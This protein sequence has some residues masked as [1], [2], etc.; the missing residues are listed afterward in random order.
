[1]PEISC[2]NCNATNPPGSKFC[3]GCGKSLPAV[4]PAVSTF[5]TG[6]CSNCGRVNPVGSK[7]CEGCGT[8]LGVAPPELKPVGAACPDCGVISPEGSKFCERCGKRLTPATT[9]E[10]V[11]EPPA[12]VVTVPTPPAAD[13]DAPLSA[14]VSGDDLAATSPSV[15]EPPE[16]EIQPIIQAP[17]VEAQTLEAEPVSPKSEPPAAPPETFV[18]SPV[19]P[20]APAAQAQSTSENTP[21]APAS[22]S[23]APT[24]ITATEKTETPIV[25]DSL[26]PVAPLVSSSTGGAA[27]Q[28]ATT[29]PAFQPNS[30]AAQLCPKCG[31]PLLENAKFCEKCGTRTASAPSPAPA[32]TTPTW[33]PDPGP[34]TD[35]IF[36]TPQSTSKGPFM[37]IA[38]LLVVLA[39]AGLAAWKFFSGPDVTV[40]V[41]QPRVTASP[42]E[43]VSLLAS[44]SGSSDTD[45][46]WS[47]KEG[48]KGGRLSPE[49]VSM[50][51]G[52]VQSAASYLA[53]QQAGTYHVTA[54]S[55]ANS[56]R[57]AIIE[58]VVGGG[59]ASGQNSSGSA[60]GSLSEQI[61]GTWQWPKPADDVRMQIAADGSITIESASQ[62]TNPRRGTYRISGDKHIEVKMD[63]GETRKFDLLSIDGDS[64][65]V[66]SE[67][68]DGVSAM[69][70]TRT[71]TGH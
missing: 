3:Q 16:K 17:N 61:V 30:S 51:E 41:A 18:Y 59:S 39:L 47:L 13:N 14:M 10:A 31:T 71:A 53:P 28:P 48:S 7:F 23:A 69:T 35:Q 12:P 19:I 32:K 34:K 62:A 38:V 50:V 58:I 1:M 54:A 66:M 29:V 36:I 44:V 33:T 8:R 45:V 6:G 49:G 24:P 52:R 21:S 67:S 11:T 43:T 25:E 37:L 60:G 42:G 46:I 56:N 40:T 2:A 22:S 26:S 65:R 68:R 63:D 70:F 57:K 27:V 20:I 55:H 15:E 4:V 64:M 9:V 5:A